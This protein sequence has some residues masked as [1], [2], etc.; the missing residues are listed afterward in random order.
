MVLMFR[1]LLKGACTQLPVKPASTKHP[2]TV[3]TGQR[4][5]LDF[6]ATKRYVTTTRQLIPMRKYLLEPAQKTYNC[7]RYS[8]PGNNHSSA[9]LQHL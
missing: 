7:D 2:L 1:E 5:V 9:Y 3:P 4:S 8:W 6:P